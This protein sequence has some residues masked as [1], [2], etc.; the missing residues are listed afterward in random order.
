MITLTE[1]SV[2]YILEGYTVSQ[3]RR[4]LAK[5]TVVVSFRKVSTEKDRIMYCTRRMDMI[6]KKNH[7]K[8][9]PSNIPPGNLAVFD[10][11]KKDWRS[12]RVN[13]VLRAEPKKL[14][15][16]TR[17][18]RRRKYTKDQKPG[19]A[20]LDLQPNDTHPDDRD[21]ETN[22]AIA[23]QDAN[24]EIDDIPELGDDGDVKESLKESLQNAHTVVLYEVS[25]GFKDYLNAK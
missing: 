23:A 13:R 8:G 2:E 12:F 20:Q 11:V 15:F 7:P 16:L 4:L 17:V 19:T 10:L 14:S 3:L 22:A 6:P 24:P 9:G 25:Y 18:L 1:G 5:G 21:D